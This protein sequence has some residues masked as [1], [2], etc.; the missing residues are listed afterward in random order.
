M[1]GGRGSWA[2]LLATVAGVMLAGC[3]GA[4]Q[5][6]KEPSGTFTL[7]V[8]RASFPGHQRIAK[9][10]K[11]TLVVRNSGSHTVPDVAVSIDS[12][13]AASNVPDVAS[14]QRPVWIVDDGP[15]GFASPPD[16]GPATNVQGGAVTAYTDTWALGPLPAGRTATFTWKVT[17][18][19]SGL[20]RITWTVAAGLNGKARAQLADGRIPSGNFSV[21]IAHAP[22]QVRVDPSTGRILP[23]GPVLGP[24]T[25]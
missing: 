9:Q 2:A 6:A 1:R 20:H 18:V 5:D 14:A 13:A 8:V 7:D 23:G 10:E 16:E 24:Q 21:F 15:G 3:G 19:Q 11:L 12:F 22:T 25:G 17:A 4:R